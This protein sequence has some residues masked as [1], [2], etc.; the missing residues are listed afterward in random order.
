MN[1]Q[2][3]IKFSDDKLTHGTKVVKEFD[4]GKWLENFRQF[5]ENTTEGVK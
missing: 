1:L 5:L 2:V 3:K 4:L